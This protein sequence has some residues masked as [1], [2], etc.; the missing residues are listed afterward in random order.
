MADRPTTTTCR[1]NDVAILTKMPAMGTL[2]LEPIVSRLEIRRQR[3]LRLEPD[4]TLVLEKLRDAAHLG[5]LPCATEA[6]RRPI[7]LLAGQRSRGGSR[8]GQLPLRLRWRPSSRCVGR[9]AGRSLRD[10]AVDVRRRRDPLLDCTPQPSSGCA[11]RACRRRA[12]AAAA[13]NS[14]PLG[15]LVLL[16]SGPARRRPET[17]RWT[18]RE[19]EKPFFGGFDARSCCHRRA[20][21]WVAQGWQFGWRRDRRPG[22]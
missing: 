20:A 8:R 9:C 16:A 14:P 17:A 22:D 5:A 12:A 21:A 18:R 1:I 3:R 2:S 13:A 4:Q 10:P 7:G 11:E 19:I 15:H 6:L